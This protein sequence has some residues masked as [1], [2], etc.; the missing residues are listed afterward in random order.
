[1]TKVVQKILTYEWVEPWRRKK[2]IDRVMAGEKIIRVAR[3]LDIRYGNA[4]C[5]I[6]AFKRS[7]EHASSMPQR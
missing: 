2:L 6:R 1:M 3:Q 7:V 4:K 5:I